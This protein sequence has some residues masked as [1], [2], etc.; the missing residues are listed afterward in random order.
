MATTKKTSRLS[1][2]AMLIHLRISMWTGA[3]RNKALSNKVC[4]DLGAEQDAGAWW[5]YYI[6][7]QSLADIFTARNVCR[8][9]W[10]RE[11]LPWM[12]GSLRIIAAPAFLEFSG[13][14]RTAVSDFQKAADAFI[15]NEYPQIRTQAQKRLGKIGD[16][17]QMPTASEIK[18]RFHIKV[19]VLP[20]PEVTDFRCDIGNEEM[21]DIKR[22]SEQSI[23]DMS[24]KAMAEVWGQLAELVAK[25]EKTLADKDKK[26]KNSLI[27]NLKEYCDRIPKINLTD[28]EKL[29]EMRK[30]V[31]AKL[32]TLD[33]DTLRTAAQPRKDAAK[34]AKALIEKMKEYKK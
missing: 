14:M 22:Q 9:L 2:K 20:V 25:V 4:A 28:D 13:K 1:E 17:R 32:T 18:D 24:A 3:H 7:K 26:F 30:E 12:D 15:T 6:P 27:D 16:G 10:I 29:E 23:K 11:T 21:E 8:N 33:C 34:T 5:T 19:D 31:Q